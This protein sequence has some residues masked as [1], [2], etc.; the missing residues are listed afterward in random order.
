[1]RVTLQRLRG[2]LEDDPSD[3]TLLQTIPGVGVRLK[4]EPPPV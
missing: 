3:P 4:S 1:V 2:K